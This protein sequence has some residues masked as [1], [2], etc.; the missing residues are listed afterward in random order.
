MSKPSSAQRPARPVA[1]ANRRP[2]AAAAAPPSKRF[3]IALIAGAVL[4]AGLVAVIVITMGSG[5]SGEL[6]VGAPTVTGDA[7]PP[8]DTIDNDTSL[9]LP[10]PEVAG[11]G[12]AGAPVSI[13]RDGRAKVLMFFAHWCGVCQQ[14]V[15]LI[16]DWLPGATLPEGVDLISIATGISSSKPNYPSSEWLASEGWTVPLILDDA[17]SSVGKAFGLTAYPYFVF[18]NAEGQVVLRLTGG[19]PIATIESII[20]E[21][22]QA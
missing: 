8:F 7:L 18:V 22:A 20:A 12:F 13:G 19:L 17:E 21:L 11:A 4:A 1:S 10:I 15:P 3:P 5:S 14:E 9:G 6:E 2:A 16:M